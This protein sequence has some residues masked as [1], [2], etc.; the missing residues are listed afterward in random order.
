MD[1]GPETFLARAAGDS[2]A[3]RFGDG[4]YL[5]VD[6]DEPAVGG[7]FVAVRSG[8]NGETD[9]GLLVEVEGRRPLRALQ[10]GWR[11][12]VLD[13]D[14]ETGIPGVVVFAGERV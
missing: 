3:P 7:R 5:C 6:P 10:P 13:A 8:A 1:Y 14:N 9:V 4:D 2:M 12:R 11:E